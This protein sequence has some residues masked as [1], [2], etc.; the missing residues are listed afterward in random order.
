MNS[1]SATVTLN[2]FDIK[3]TIKPGFWGTLAA[4]WGVMTWV[5]GRGHPER[6]L[7]ARLCIG[8]VAVIIMIPADLAHAFAHTLSA[9]RA[10]APMDEIVLGMHMP[11]TLY[12]DNDVPPTAHRARA[13][14]GPVYS[15][16]ALAADLA[17][18]QM[19]PHDS[20]LHDLLGWSA[21]ANAMILVGSLLPL[22]FVDGGSIL[23]WSLVERGLTEE[24]AD[25]TVRQVN[26]GLGA[27]AGAA[28]AGLVATRHRRAGFSLLA[29]AGFLVAVGL[30]KIRQI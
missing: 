30:D 7:P 13:L 24:E 16:A 19:T 21:A 23:K 3:L 12:Y 26:L 5:A 9:K 17:T 1:Q 8:F 6:S 28:G 20:V 4:L 18:R 14:G 15:T 10:G 22:P 27:A 25:R 2:V 29:G 11:H